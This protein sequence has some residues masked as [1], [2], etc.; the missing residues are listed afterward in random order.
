MQTVLPTLSQKK[1]FN[2]AGKVIV[3]GAF[4]L[5]LAVL[6]KVIKQYYEGGTQKISS[7]YNKNPASFTN[8][9]MPFEKNGQ[10]K[11]AASHQQADNVDTAKLKQSDWFTAVRKD[12]DKRMYNVNAEADG[13]NYCSINAAQGLKSEY[14]TEGFTLQTIPSIDL[15]KNKT[16]KR[17]KGANEWHLSLQV[18]GVYADNQLLKYSA[19]KIATTLVNNDVQYNFGDAYTIQYH[20]D[21]NGV[22][23]NF[24]IK[25]K[26]AENTQ[27]LKVR[28]HAQGDWVIDKVHNRE[29]HFAKQNKRDGLDNKI[30]YNDLKVWDADGKILAAKMIV[31]KDN[32]FEIIADAEN[33]KYPVTID[34]LSTSASTSLS[35]TAGSFGL[36]VA[37]AGD[38]NG[39]GYS[40]VIVGGNDGS[41]SIY[42]GSIS[43]L[44]SSAAT[45]LTGAG[46]FGVAVAS[47]GDVNGDGF[48]DVIIGNGLG[49]AF[50]FNG[51]GAGIASGTSATAAAT[52]AG[53]TLHF[54]VSV[55]NAGD[56]NGDGYSDVIIGDGGG[57]AYI[58]NGSVSGITSGTIATASAILTGTGPLFGASVASAGD[59]NADG[60]S[61]VIIGDAGGNAFVFTSTG[62]L[63]I[64]S[65]TSATATVSLTGT[66]ALFGASVASAGD[67]NGD[68][69]SDVIVGNAGGSAF[70][71][72][73]SNSSISNT[74]TA[75]VLAGG[76]NF[77][78]SVASAGDVNGDAFGDVVVGDNNGNAFVYLGNATALPT[79]AST[80]LTGSGNFGNSV[81]SAGDVN[82]DGYSDVVVGASGSGTAFIYQGSPDG[83]AVTN[84]ITLNGTNQGDQFGYS[85]SS[86]GDVNADGFSDV[87]VGAN[88]YIGGLSGPPGTGNLGAFYL[89]LGSASGLST[90]PS[91]TPISGPAPG[92]GAND[93]NFGISVASAGDVNG[94]GYADVVIGG[95]G[96]NSGTDTYEGI[97]YI[98][99]GGSGGLS[100]SF[101]VINCP[102][103][104]NFAEFGY[105]VASAGDINGD[106]YSDVVIGAANLDLTF[107]GQG[108]AF[109][110]YGSPTG[111]V[112]S[113]L[114]AVTVATA[115][116][117]SFGW[118]VASA[119]DVNGDGFSDIIVGTSQ[120]NAAYIYF[121]SAIGIINNASPDITLTIGG[122]HSFGGSVASAGDVNGDGYSDVLVSDPTGNF[123]YEGAVYLFLGSSGGTATVPTTTITEGTTIGGA[124]QFGAAV[125]SAGDVNG[126][127]YS[128][129][130]IKSAVGPVYVFEGS[131]S[132]FPAAITTAQ[133]STVYT[134]GVDASS[135]GEF[136]NHLSVGSAGDVN[137]DGYSDVI[138]G[139][140]ETNT[141]TGT[142]Y[143]YYG[144]AAA[145]LNASNVL[146][147]YETDLA[148]PLK[149]DNVHSHQFGLGLYAQSPFGHV[150]GRLVWEVVPN[151]LPFSGVPITNSV[152]RTSQ[153]A[154]YS[155]IA[156]G[157]TLFK[158]LV[159]KAT[160][161]ATKVRTRIQ[162]ASTAVTF[163]QRYSPW[164]YSQVYLTTGTSNVLPLDLISLTATP[165]D[166]NIVLNWKTAQEQGTKNFIIE[167]S[168]D[169][170]N[171]APLDSVNAKGNTVTTTSYDY[172]HYHPS[173][174]IH[175]YRLKEVD[176]DGHFTY[177]KTVSATIDANGPE[178]SVYPNPASDQLI[179]TFTGITQSSL[180]RIIDGAG[181]V[182]RQYSFNANSN[183]TTVS[184]KGVSKGT[185]F[186]QLVN[187]GFVPKQISIQ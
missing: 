17:D 103:A 149:A 63:G 40:D 176:I 22:R 70:V 87:I 157:G 64:I 58:F 53:V 104:L 164:I 115:D 175:Y 71:F 101:Q 137:G 99:F 36:S 80:N 100:G 86:A 76:A 163:G 151:G 20:N 169:D 30:T 150:S 119:G 108:A 93:G 179:I 6:P 165:V 3:L 81:G 19:D 154:S 145:G 27:Q 12:L 42:L 187:S 92:Q 160:S 31:E 125:G 94:D 24:I 142:A 46:A 134:D 178:F 62:T 49:S 143:I 47:A 131:S 37:S 129:I 153:Q 38:I 9:L 121:G 133:A 4:T 50:I 75:I 23:Q 107:S 84:T 43:G 122:S 18:N 138:Q 14:T 35:G 73:S 177:S 10:N 26:P 69:Y 106:G 148:T 89:Y 97:A 135:D 72:T 147:L 25:Q 181:N 111:L 161:K 85:V 109:I 56:V 60:F 152:T 32:N 112:T 41:V 61:D 167:H 174:G 124:D 172:T 33:A 171:F 77:G 13:K 52:L 114:T 117:T 54:G 170:I 79:T 74:T 102:G 15:L 44:S 98:Y 1:V 11:H 66:G 128:D 141:K 158:N 48:S 180:I 182:V 2:S 65:G 120:G 140:Y 8:R 110:F 116:Y 90:T 83:S 113:T 127:G 82:G 173:I 29:L 21:E 7:S 39:D 91:G 105:S 155:F 55:A 5:S 68:G 95:I 136:Q 59:I 88:G 16:A 146:H 67:I 144:N 156:P 168:L 78:A 51:S 166:K 130:V 34:P 123:N 184:L 183:Q 162:Y 57:S 159:D 126:D 96:Y 118:S 132:P 45:V 139:V 185:Y 186:V 28:M